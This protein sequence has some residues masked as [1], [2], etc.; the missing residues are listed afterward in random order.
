MTPATPLKAAV[1]GWP[2]EHS[3]SPKLHQFWL[4]RYKIEGHYSALAVAPEDLETSLKALF[5]MGF[6]GVNLTVPHKETGLLWVDRRDEIAKR[7][8]AINMVVV[9]KDG[10]LYGQNSDVFG[11]R[12]NLASTGKDLKNKPVTLLG[13]GGAAR[14]AIVALMDLGV[15]RIRVMNRTVERAEQL[16]KDFGSVI[17]PHGWGDQKAFDQTALLVNA[18]SLGLKGQPKLTLDLKALPKTALV[19][20]M[21]YA[22]LMTDLL[23]EAKARGNPILD[24]LGMLLHQ[25]RPAFKAFF[26]VDAEV[27]DQLRSYMSEGL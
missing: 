26:G 21:V 1:M 5:H 7:V 18:T 24:G 12:E 4:K 10:T 15:A 2:I 11:F 17:A 27:D 22:P 13:A 14:A 16:A 19:H 8:G 9:Q 25:A 3:L 23:S 20:D 6:S